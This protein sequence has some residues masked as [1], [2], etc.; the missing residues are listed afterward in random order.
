T[1]SGSGLSTLYWKMRSGP[2]QRIAD[3][4]VPYRLYRV[5]YNMGRVPHSTFFAMDAVDGSLDLFTFPQLPA[6]SDLVTIHTQNRITPSLQA[7]AAESA[8]RQ[9]VLR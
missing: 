5:H 1:F 6:A 8:L 3:A 7:S 2:L 9:K 4:Y